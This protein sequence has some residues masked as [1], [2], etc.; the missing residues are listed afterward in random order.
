MAKKLKL[1]A[2]KYISYPDIEHSTIEELLKAS[3]MAGAVP[4]ESLKVDG[5]TPQEVAKCLKEVKRLRAMSPI[6]ARME[7]VTLQ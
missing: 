4:S 2:D 7:P 3:G 1:D 6:Q 5:L